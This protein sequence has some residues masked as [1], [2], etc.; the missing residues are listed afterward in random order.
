[1]RARSWRRAERLQEDLEPLC[2]RAR[3][4]GAGAVQHQCA[5]RIPAGDAELVPDG[6][7][8][9]Q[10]RPR[11]APERRDRRPDRG[12][13][14]AISASS[15]APSI[16]AACRRFRSAATASCWWSR[17]IIRSPAARASA[18]PR[19]S[20]TTWSASIAPARSSASSPTRRTASAG[21]CGCACSC[22]ASTRSAAWSNAMSASASC[23]RRRCSGRERNM[24]ISAVRLT[25]AW[26]LRELTICVRDVDALPP[27][28]RQLVDHLRASARRSARHQHPVI[29]IE[30]HRRIVLVAAS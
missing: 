14:R 27:Y 20:T 11:G 23:R 19:C 9:Y 26:A 18:L 3:R 2:A 6:L 13:R 5:H 22:A 10:R 16:T 28:A 30:D 15:P 4:P 1:M 21:R 17:A 8:R 29:E 25:D 12:R 24:A 7:S